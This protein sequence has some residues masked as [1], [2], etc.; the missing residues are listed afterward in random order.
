MN[1][2][3]HCL[4]IVAC[5]N[6]SQTSTL[7]NFWETVW[8]WEQNSLER[9]N[10]WSRKYQSVLVTITL[11]EKHS[12]PTLAVIWFRSYC[13]HIWGWTKKQKT[14]PHWLHNNYQ[15]TSENVAFR[16]DDTVA[17]VTTCEI[18]G[19]LRGILSVEVTYAA[20]LKVREWR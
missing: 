9:A 4:V 11:K 16:Q 5:T 15:F 1:H 7:T 14:G 8:I 3:N 17:T 13:R 19:V 2:L 20:W 6:T 10:T 12:G 18:Y